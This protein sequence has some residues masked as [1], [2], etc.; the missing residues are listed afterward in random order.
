[1]L[2]LYLSF[3]TS[4]GDRTHQALTLP[5]A[6]GSEHTPPYTHVHMYVLHMHVSTQAR[7]L[8]GMCTAA[9][10]SPFI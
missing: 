5:F 10:T 7:I 6:P 4:G 1:M 9:G 2:P 3:L 8:T